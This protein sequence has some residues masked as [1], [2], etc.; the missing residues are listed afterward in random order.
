MTRKTLCVA[1]VSMAILM[2]VMAAV[3]QA[4]VITPIG[5]TASSSYPGSNPLNA[6]ENLLA[7]EAVF[8][9]DGNPFQDF[10]ATGGDANIMGWTEDGNSYGR[11]EW[12][13]G[14]AVVNTTWLLFDLGG[15]KNLSGIYL[16]NFTQGMGRALDMFSVWSADSAGNTISELTAPGTRMPTATWP[17]ITRS[18]ALTG[19]NSVQYVKLLVG[20][21]SADVTSGVDFVGL[22]EVRFEGTAV[23]EPSM[24][25]LLGAGLLSLLAYAWR[26]RK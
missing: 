8:M 16:W 2:V 1:S 14:S 21:N 19:A 4:A 9:M 25:V 17:E 11:G 12:M 10:H 3:G 15:A 13:S 7:G 6:P 24:F 20:R 26:K 23:P 22:G 5:V 18:F